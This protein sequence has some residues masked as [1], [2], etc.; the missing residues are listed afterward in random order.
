MNCSS[1]KAVQMYI[2]M[3]YYF[4][5]KRYERCMKDEKLVL[6]GPDGFLAPIAAQETLISVRSSVRPSG[7]N[8]S[9]AVNLNHSG[10]NIQAIS[11]E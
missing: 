11:Q 2:L 6:S 7:S 3:I 9:R 10:S 8:L 5:E 1:K 4:S